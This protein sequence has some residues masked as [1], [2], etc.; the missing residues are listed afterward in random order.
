[1]LDMCENQTNK[2]CLETLKRLK[3]P[4]TEQKQDRQDLER[5]VDRETV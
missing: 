2:D 3:N 4:T 5:I 1:M